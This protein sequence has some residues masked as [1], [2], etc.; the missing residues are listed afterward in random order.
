GEIIVP[1]GQTVVV[2]APLMGMLKAP[3]GGVPQPGKLVKKGQP[4][5][6][7]LP[8]LTPE[9]QNTMLT[10]K[11]NAEGSLKTAQAQLHQAKMFFT[12]QTGALKTGTIS[13]KE[14]EQAQRDLKVAEQTHEAAKGLRDSLDEVIASFDKGTAKALAIDCPEE[15]LL[16]KLN[17][18]PG[19]LV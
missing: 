7:L 3:A 8:Q 16:L 19:Q 15:G 5:F 17:A 2:S 11:V 12:R 1:V 14:F 18:V 9:A 4:V 10:Q 6:E 13:K